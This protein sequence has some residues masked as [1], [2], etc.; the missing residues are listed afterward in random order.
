MR[1]SQEALLGD[2]ATY[3]FYMIIGIFFI[4]PIFWSFSVALGSQEDVLSDGLRILPKNP[5]LENFKAVLAFPVFS[6]YLW[7]ALKLSFFGALGASLICLPSAYAF[8][9]FDWKGRKTALI[10]I[11]VFKM[12]S[13]I[14]ILVPL[15]RYLRMMGLLDSHLVVICVYI[16]V[17]IPMT[18][19]LLKGFCDKVPRSLEE[20]AMIDGCSRLGAMFRVVLPTLISGLMASFIINI[21]T[22]WGNFIIPFILLS[23]PKLLPIAV[24]LLKFQGDYEGGGQELVAAASVLSILPAVLIFVLLQRMIIKSMTTGAVKG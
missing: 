5:T 23:K 6:L 16:G 18:T 17:Q 24:G 1:Q 3:L 7:N 15:Y 10:L 11:L 9:R 20:S 13:G 14:I 12:F 19:W 2:L 8:S 21:I 22:N 4:F